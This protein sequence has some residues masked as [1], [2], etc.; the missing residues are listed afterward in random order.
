MS[1]KNL[2]N[3]RLPGGGYDT[4]EQIRDKWNQVVSAITPEQ[5]INFCDTEPESVWAFAN[6]WDIEVLYE[7]DYW[8]QVYKKLILYNQSY[9]EYVYQYYQN[10]KTRF[11]QEQADEL[12]ELGRPFL[13]EKENN[14]KLKL[15]MCEDILTQ[16]SNTLNPS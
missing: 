3:I 16:F 4:E 9:V 13:E 11:T 1:L 12:R 15:K 5:W 8:F 14:K 7:S 2:I 6:S 10:G